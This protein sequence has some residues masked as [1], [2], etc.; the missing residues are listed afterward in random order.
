VNLTRGALRNPYL[1]IVAALLLVVI[2]AFSI[3]RM[4]TDLLPRF[5][6]PAVQVLTLYP[7]MPAEVVEA[8]I[9]SRLERWTGQANGVSRQV[10]RSLTGVSVVRD[11]FRDDID[12]NT[13]MSQVSALAASDVYYLPPG[14]APPMVMPFDPTAPIPL[15]LLAVSSPTA[16][17]K[18]LYDIAYFRLRNLLQGTPGVIAPAV[19]GGKIRRILVRVDR[20]KLAA[21]NLSPMDV[22]AALRAQN[23][24]VPL[25]NLKAGDLDYQLETN[26]M[27]T[28]V[29]AI[30]HFPITTGTESPVLVQD[31]G[32]TEDT[33]QI[34]S[35]VVRIDGRRQV[36]IPIYRQ[37]GAN[38]ISVVAEVRAALDRL[39]ASLPSG[40]ELS[41]AVDQSIFVR[42]AINALLSE[43][44][45]GALLAGLM[46]LLFL[47]SLKASAVVMI[48]IPLSVI[49]ALVTLYFTGDSLNAMT[50]GGL[51]LAIGRLV[52]DAIVVLENTVRHVQLGKTP[53][54]A[55]LDAAK[56]VNAPVLVATLATC[57]VF[58]P[59]LFLRGMGR[60]LFAPLALAVTFAM[61][62]SYLVAMTIV[63]LWSRR[64]LRDAA[65]AHHR[66]DDRRGW[67]GRLRA[68]YDAAL[69]RTVRRPIA[70][71]IVGLLAV[72]GALLIAPRV[73]REL[74]PRS[75]SGQM[76]MT[77]R[78]PSG[79]R[80]EKTE[81][82]VARAETIIRQTIPADELSILIS[83]AG[84]LYDWPAA[85]TPNAGTADA[86]VQIELT[87]RRRHSTEAY[88]DALRQAFAVHLPEVEVAFDTGGMLTAALSDG[89]ISPI[90][91]AIEGAKG[92][93]ATRVVRE[94]IARTRSVYGAVDVR[95]Q[96]RFDLPSVRVDVDRVRAAALGLTEKDVIQNVAAAL[97]SSVNFDPAFWIDPKNG[98]HYFLGVQYREG[99]ASGFDA[100]LD[101]PITPKNGGGGV[102]L[103]Q[104]ASL[105]R[106]VT[107]GEVRHE[108]IQR[109]LQV[110][111][112]V[113]GR[114]VGS[115]SAE[116]E[117]SLAA[118]ALPK[119]ARVEV[120]GETAT[121]RRSFTDLGG[122]IGLA[123][124]LVYL[125]L[126]A[127]FRSFR[128]PLLVLA[129]VPLGAV[130]ALGLLWITGST[131]NVQSLVGMLFTVGI[132]VSNSVLLVDFSGRLRADGRSSAD[133]AREAA[134]V[135]LR[136]ILMTSLAAILGL[137]PM[138]IGFGRGSEANVP[139]ARAVVGGLTTS[140]I[141]TLL[142]V[143]ALDAWMHRNERP[144]PLE[145]SEGEV[146]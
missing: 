142:I 118:I 13:A 125:L 66:D 48:A 55:A 68:G 15:V 51:A 10:S 114:D 23:V 96:E 46:I 64:I 132:A 75:D 57:V 65:V 6:T 93:D 106:H 113:R 115:V 87:G 39:R 89:A 52:D 17:E 72:G 3:P 82:Y 19:Y 9:T 76:T 22:S 30:D 34:Q 101:V 116:I 134:L 28:T 26:G 121:M 60:F 61:L 12:P 80:L 135:R 83:N 136:P 56:E 33:A 100:A 109:V 27:P 29:D 24:L 74:F 88:A 77:L 92:D 79:T 42:Q 69:G 111:A 47:R 49:A 59:V 41:L 146:V 58:V 67:F 37:P 5:K 95:L 124:M 2:G 14:T 70:M 139:L 73:G 53:A 54:S 35:N 90:A 144:V 98:N 4:P 110:L 131:L 102:P 137:L 86:F 138:A 129:A 141:L 31:I 62:A 25:G 1:V 36:Y 44:V 122:G 112:N 117:R 63:P 107:V 105:S 38:T 43:A 104:V 127:Q 145:R 97:T 143:P 103:R 81:A 7:G 20:E 140:T 108:N 123:V 130:G 32:K 45:V 50:L 126:V 18:E 40:I 94:V 120:R 16:S 91:I 119:G 84:V 133:A 128:A 99:P 71:S 85:Y 78:A 21:R 11:Y 8:D